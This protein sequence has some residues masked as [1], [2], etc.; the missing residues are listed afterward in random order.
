MSKPSRDRP[1]AITEL[2]GVLLGAGDEREHE[3]TAQQHP[4]CLD[5]TAAHALVYRLVPVVEGTYLLG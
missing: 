3:G 1:L 4:W 5:V 2:G